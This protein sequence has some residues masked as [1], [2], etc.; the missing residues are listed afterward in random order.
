MK[1][2]TAKGAKTMGKE[3]TY[4]FNVKVYRDEKGGGMVGPNDMEVAIT[5]KN[6]KMPNTSDIPFTLVDGEFEDISGNDS[7]IV[8]KIDSQTVKHIVF[9]GMD[10]GSPFANIATAKMAYIYFWSIERN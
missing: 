9:V 8:L 6:I 1:E 4:R 5:G 2:T 7:A 10:V 3:K